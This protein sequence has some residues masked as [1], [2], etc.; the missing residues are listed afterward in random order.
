VHNK[1]DSILELANEVAA[2][3]YAMARVSD[4][5]FIVVT[6]DIAYSGS[7]MEYEAVA[8]FL[9]QI[10]NQ[11]ENEGCSLVEVLM[12]PGNHDCVLK[13]EKKS[14]DLIISKIIDAPEYAEDDS[15]IESCVMAQDNYF[16]FRGDVTR[17]K[18]SFDHKLL[19]EYE[20]VVSDKVVRFSAIN[21]SWMSQLPEKAGQLVYPAN[22]FKDV[23]SEPA[24]LR[25]VML[26]HPLNW[27]CPD[28]FHEL[29]ALIRTHA[30]VILSGHEHESH[31]GE[32]T[33]TNM[34]TSLFF[35]ANALQPHAPGEFGGFSV[36]HFD[37]GADP[38]LKNVHQTNFQI[39]GNSINV[40]EENDLSLANA[41]SSLV[42]QLAFTRGFLK[43]I[44]NPGGGFIHP[45][46]ENLQIDDL[47][48]YPEL[49]SKRLNEGNDESDIGKYSVP[50]E[51]ILFSEID[52][53]RLI[54][55]GEDRSGKTTLIYQALKEY[56][57][58]GYAPIY[59]KAYEINSFTES[60]FE[61]YLSK[62]AV[63]QYLYPDHFIR[64]EKHKR[65]VLVDDLDRIKSLNM[66]LKLVQMLETQFNAIVLTAATGFEISELVNTEAAKTLQKY[67]AYGVLR[68]G[69][70][71]RHKLIRKWCLCGP[72]ATLPELDKK[73]HDAEAIVNTVVG[74]NLVPS[75]PFYLLILLQ[76]SAQNQQAE[77]KNSSFAHY[78]EYLMTGNLTKAGVKRDQYDE[79]FNYLANLA[80]YFQE[81]DIDEASL[82]ELGNFNAVF[83]KRFIKVDLHPRLELLVTGKLLSRRGDYFSFSY[84]YVF[85]F[86]LGRFLAKN[87]HK[88]EIKYFV[89]KLCSQLSL[90]KNSHAILF[91]TYHVNDP[92]VIEQVATVLSGCFSASVPIELN[93]DIAFINDL[94]A[95]TTE[96][97]LKIKQ[98]DIVEN[99]SEVRKLRDEQDLLERDDDGAIEAAMFSELNLFIKTGEI[100]G[101]I[102]KIYYGSLER[103]TKAQLIKEVF[104]APLRFLR[105]VFE[106]I[107]KDPDAF[108]LEIEK[109][110]LLKSPELQSLK[111]GV[112]ARDVA[113]QFLGQ[114]CTGVIL[115]TSM[116]I[117]SDKL[118]DDIAD[119]LGGKSS[120][121]Y[122]LI[123][124]G[125]KFCSPKSLPLDEIRRLSMDLKNNAFA[126]RVLQSLGA[127]HIHQFHLKIEDKQKL[128]S[129]LGIKIEASQLVD[130]RTKKSKLLK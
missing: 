25:F 85:F 55:L 114:L 80:W 29:R 99:Q 58:L 70:A 74:R 19:T 46:K 96:E 87:L 51:E 81:S 65:I 49:E 129:Y 72:V 98:V 14:R 39:D 101:Q 10:K 4:A 23:I 28:T 44:C 78:Y 67:S 59:I 112:L 125:T 75:Q 66:I 121:A 123:A 7:S 38:E 26:H 54:I 124:V 119:L 5:C 90:H 76:S 53:A 3:C 15:V 30:T 122:K 82:I 52:G 12:V 36:L 84:P 18:S 37:L 69:H 8:P 95:N 110:V 20:F 128:C 6:G 94:V 35:E 32:I 107:S 97:V 60:D 108:I 9:H 1:E 17:A 105:M 79:L 120:T 64:A 100:L 27:Y 83:S 77:L 13:P 16:Q 88:P 102:V 40:I 118:D 89:T 50:A 48:V 91:L 104:D 115:R 22:K 21:A 116:T 42:P 47:F 117:S 24:E 45:D 61:R 127:M 86:F 106:Q 73:V 41:N 111:K 33:E 68:F 63:E 126:F 62:C 11:I 130:Y 103:K 2:T 93:G 109:A 43:S 71:L 56:H 113:Y 57:T 31:S 34:G 92:W